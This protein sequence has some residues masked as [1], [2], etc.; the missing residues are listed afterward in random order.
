MMWGVGGFA[1]NLFAPLVSGGEEVHLEE[2]GFAAGRWFDVL[3]EGGAA[4][5]PGNRR[6]AT[7]RPR[8]EGPHPTY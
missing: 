6:G 3:K 2:D 8:C 5:R 7:R 1:C 4:V